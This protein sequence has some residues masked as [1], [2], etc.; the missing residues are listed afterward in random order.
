MAF[1][2]DY[3]DVA[4]RLREM[5]EIYP[6]LTLTQVDLKFITFGGQDWVVYT[7][8]AYRTPDDQRPG[9]ASAWECIPGKT[10]Y[11]KDSELQNAETSAWGRALVAIGA[12]TRKGIAT[13]EDVKAR[14]YTSRPPKRSLAEIL[15][16][17]H[18]AAEQGQ[19]G[20]LRDLYR[21]ASAA[22]ASESELTILS[23]LAAELAAIQ[24]ASE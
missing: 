23:G 7:A 13:A 24:K 3:V 20:T 12:D 17:A 9:V 5:R 8:A 11:T 19:I 1:A 14:E 16:E 18:L 15:G 6:Q 22:G 4:Q 10:P 2:K 21:E